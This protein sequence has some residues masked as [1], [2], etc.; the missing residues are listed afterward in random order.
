MTPTS[1]LIEKAQ[2]LL[3]DISKPTVGLRDLIDWRR[4]RMAD[5][6]MLVPDLLDAL[7]ESED[8]I[9]ELRAAVIQ[10]VR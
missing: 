3:L 6:V 5:L 4:S 2:G 9:T 7:R 1:D 10:K 8:Y